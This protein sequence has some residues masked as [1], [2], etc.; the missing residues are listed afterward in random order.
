MSERIE[1]LA[2]RLSV[3]KKALE[4]RRKKLRMAKSEDV[5]RD[6]LKWLEEAWEENREKVR[7]LG[8]SGGYS[9]FW[10]GSM[11]ASERHLKGNLHHEQEGIPEALQEEYSRTSWDTF[12]VLKGE[13]K[14][15]R[16]ARSRA[17]RLRQAEF[18]LRKSGKSHEHYAQT[19]D[20]AIE[21]M[22]QE[23]RAA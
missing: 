9:E 10:S 19:V 21:A 14:A 11:G 6:L 20:A 2:A 22:K 13:E 16:E 5:E 18:E 1:T 4:T 12:D 7:R 8:K 23:A 17:E 3:S 15:K